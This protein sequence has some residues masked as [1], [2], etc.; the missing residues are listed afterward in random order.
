MSEQPPRFD[1]M[2]YKETMGERW[3]S[4]DPVIYQETMREQW[5]NSAE[6]WHRWIPVVRTWVGHATEMMLDLAQV[7]TGARVLDIAAGD[8]DQSLL[9]AAR[10]GPTGFVLATDIAPNLVALASQTAR[11]KGLENLDA[12]VMDA[13]N[14]TVDDEAFDVVI[15]RLG[16]FFLPNLP[17]A[18][19]EI[20]RVLKP[21]GRVGGIVISTPDKNPFLSVPISII[22]RHAQLGPPLPGQPGPFS[23]GAPGALASA[24]ERA[25]FSEVRTRT[26]SAP[27]RMASARECARFEREAFGALHQMLAALTEAARTQAWQEV[28]REL[29][30][31]EGHDGFESPCE[32]VIVTAVKK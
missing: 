4:I 2:N 22:R 17:R 28:E 23:L 32:I 24:L 18:L 21:A 26:I 7:G 19:S 9:A 10:V 5:Q 30:K 12:R 6:G 31:Y 13:E 11:E 27:L 16:L 3:Q 20:R 15:C 14:L 29:G 1:P 25:G 8:G